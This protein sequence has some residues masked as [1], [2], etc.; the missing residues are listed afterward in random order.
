MIKSNQ[1]FDLEAA[2]N[3]RELGGYRTKDGKMTKNKVYLRGG[4]TNNLTKNDVKQLTDYGVKLEIDLRSKLEVDEQ[5]SILK[6]IETI[7]Y[8]HI[9]MLDGL[10]T[11]REKNIIPSTMYEVYV[12]L[13]ENGKEDYK[14]IFKSILKH[15]GVTLFHCSAGKDRTGVLALLI[16]GLANVDNEIIIADYAVSEDNISNL[17]NKAKEYEILH[18]TTIPKQFL[19]SKREDME[20]TIEYISNKYNNVRGYLKEVGLSEKELNELNDRFIE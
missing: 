15:N 3:V 16:L 20:N 6:N 18:N 7:E 8:Q 11:M 10:A 1:A 9:P 14:K 2:E 19:A 12:N 13:L 5:P 4:N 17:L